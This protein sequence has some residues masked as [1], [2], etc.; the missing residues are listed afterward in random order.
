MSAPL[1]S[2][3][4]TQEHGG[5]TVYLLGKK[6]SMCKWNYAVQTPAV[7]GSADVL[8]LHSLRPSGP[9]CLFKNSI[10]LTLSSATTV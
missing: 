2:G 1:H 7:Q 3:C 4:E 10:D 6:K 8:L 5:L 9:I